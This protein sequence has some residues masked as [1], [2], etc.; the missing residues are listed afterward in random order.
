[1][2]WYNITAKLYEIDINSKLTANIQK[3]FVKNHYNSKYKIFE[4]N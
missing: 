3:M 4:S 2:K 1:M